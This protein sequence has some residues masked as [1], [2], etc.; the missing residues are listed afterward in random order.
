LLLR[1]ANV[2]TGSHDKRGFPNL[3]TTLICSKNLRRRIPAGYGLI[4]YAA[5]LMTSIEEAVELYAE[6][7]LA[8]AG[9]AG[10]ASAF[11]GRERSFRPVERMRLIGVVTLSASVFG[12]CLAFLAASIA[13]LPSSETETL[14]GLASLALLSP[15]FWVMPRLWIRA[16]DPD[17][18]VDSW[19]LYLVTILTFVETLLLSSAALGFGAGWQLALSFGF[20]LLEG[21]W[22][23]F[24][25]LTRQN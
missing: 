24:L 15:L 14:A 16:R 25:L 8:L 12:G 21:L 23:F 19:S 1:R 13:L 17:A 22:L 5:G 6:L 3:V 7:S 2:R 4:R 10:V 9:F 18:N 11:A 20:Q